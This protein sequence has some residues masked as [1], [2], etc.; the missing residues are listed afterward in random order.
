MGKIA[1][2]IKSDLSPKPS[3]ISIDLS[4]D[5]NIEIIKGKAALRILESLKKNGII[6]FAV[7]TSDDNIVINLI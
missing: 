7:Y 2:G 1:Y 4:E 3:P 5:E 6:D